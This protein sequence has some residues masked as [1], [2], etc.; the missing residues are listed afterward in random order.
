MEFVD[1]RVGDD[2]ADEVFRAKS[3]IGDL[4]VVDLHDG[5]DRRSFPWDESPLRKLGE[6]SFNSESVFLRISRN[7]EAFDVKARS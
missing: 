7:V 6:E 5:V 3:E 1:V 4:A 2:D